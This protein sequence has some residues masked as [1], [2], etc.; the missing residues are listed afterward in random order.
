[1]R[2][3]KSLVKDDDSTR[4]ASKIFNEVMTEF[5]LPLRYSAME[6]HVRDSTSFFSSGDTALI[7]MDYDNI[8]VRE[9]DERGIKALLTRQ[10]FKAALG[11]SDDDQVN[12]EMTKNGHSD[13]LFY[14]Y[15]SQIASSSKPD[16]I[17]ECAP[18][19]R[20]FRNR[21][22]MDFMR[23]AVEAAKRRARCK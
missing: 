16:D 1:M 12:A 19:L 14:I 22:D 9:K 17:E 21:D 7:C 4:L 13:D 10:L 8:F 20:A 2:V 15:Y 5:S 23:A 6:F 18:A 3:T 11:T